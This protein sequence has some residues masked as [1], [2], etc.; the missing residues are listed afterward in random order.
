MVHF[1]QSHTCSFC[2]HYIIKLFKDSHSQSTKLKRISKIIFFYAT[3]LIIYVINLFIV[4]NLSLNIYYAN[5]FYVALF[6]MSF[7][8]LYMHLYL[9]KY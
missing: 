9:Y 4:A 5:S 8:L 1:L 2:F 6:D 7:S 3:I